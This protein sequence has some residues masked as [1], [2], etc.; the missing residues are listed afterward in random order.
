M[1]VMCYISGLICC[2]SDA[3][4]WVSRLLMYLVSV[5]FYFDANRP[6]PLQIVMC[7]VAR[8]QWHGVLMRGYRKRV[9]I[10]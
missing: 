1:C 8:E 6:L 5:P 4:Y 7:A 3:V 9:V 10:L 2:S